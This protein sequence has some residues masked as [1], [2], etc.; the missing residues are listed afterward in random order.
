MILFLIKL[1]ACS[2]IKKR[3]QDKCFHV[4]NAKFLRTTMLRNICEWL[5]LTT[6]N[7]TA[8]RL[9]INESKIHQNCYIKFYVKSPKLHAFFM[10]WIVKCELSYTLV[11]NILTVLYCALSNSLRNYLHWPLLIVES[12]RWLRNLVKQKCCCS[13]L[14]MPSYSKTEFFKRFFAIKNFRIKFHC[15]CLTGS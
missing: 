1:Q 11:Y 9:S 3:L 12:L 4:N 5:L 6:C 2:F 7:L 8:K 10:I 15:T 13:V 14:E